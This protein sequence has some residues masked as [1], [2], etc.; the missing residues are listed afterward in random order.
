MDVHKQNLNGLGRVFQY[1]GLGFRLRIWILM[2]S[3]VHY[4][5]YYL[6]IVGCAGNHSQ[7]VCKRGLC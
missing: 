1:I 2:L 4:Y 5:Y 7:K 3:D 6:V